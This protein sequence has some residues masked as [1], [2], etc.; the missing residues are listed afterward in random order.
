MWLN[1]GMANSLDELKASCPKFTDTR[2]FSNGSVWNNNLRT[3]AAGGNDHYASAVVNSDIL[4]RNLVKIYHP[5]LVTEDFV[6]FK[7]LK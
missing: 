6:Y 1:V 5:E 7:Q 2:C 4:L 3:N